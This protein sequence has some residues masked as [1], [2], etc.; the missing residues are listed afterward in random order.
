MAKKYIGVIGFLV[1]FVIAVAI[2]YSIINKPKILKIYNPA[3]LNPAIVDSSL[4]LVNKNH[5]IG[6]F[7]LTNQYGENITEST[8]EG[9]IY[10]ADFFFT[11]CPTLCPKMAKQMIRVQEKYKNN[12]SVIILSHSVM[13]ENDSIPILFEY[14][15][16]QKAIRD[17]WHFLTGQRTQIYE[18]A[19]KHYFTATTSGKGNINDL[20]HTENFVLIDPDKRI[21]GFYDGTSKNEVDILLSDIDA[22]LYEYK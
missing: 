20:I 1:V 18:L 8:T 9:K 14:A 19:R 6:K 2:A 12:P 22:L 17:K 16:E 21:R 4:R 7:S 15:K 5:R 11:T 3:E 10:I 13:P